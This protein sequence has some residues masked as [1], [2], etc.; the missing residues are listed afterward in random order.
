MEIKN[1]N[2]WMLCA[3]V[4]DSSL[5]LSA[6]QCRVGSCRLRSTGSGQC[7]K[8]VPMYLCKEKLIGF[9]A[10]LLSLEIRVRQAVMEGVALGT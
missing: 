2:Q 5:T 9:L 10:F 6:G 4:L 3:A 1:E 7:L 8:Y